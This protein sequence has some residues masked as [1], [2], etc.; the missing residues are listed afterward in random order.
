MYPLRVTGNIN[1]IT[2]PIGPK[3]STSALSL[4][5]P[6][7]SKKSLTIKVFLN[8]F[9]YKVSKLLPAIPHTPR[10]ASE[11]KDPLAGLSSTHSP[12]LGR[13]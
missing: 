11:E 6:H 13:V 2:P 9:R 4:I 3:H 7:I 10:D 5:L 1:S 8:P 12:I